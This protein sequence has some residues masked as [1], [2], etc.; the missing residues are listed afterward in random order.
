MNTLALRPRM[1]EKAYAVSQDLNT[2]VFMVPI[3][4]NKAAVTAAVSQQFKVT[5]EDVRVTVVKGKA[6][7]SYKKRSR[8]TVGHR[9]DMKKVYVR[10]KAGDS[11]PVFEAMT[12]EPKE[13]IMSKAVKKANEKAVEKAEKAEQPKQGRLRS[14]LGRAPRQTQSKGSGGK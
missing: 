11:I 12:E 5:V 6:K 9:A 14:A 1:S 10:L 2:Y 13:T 3:T 7:K 4:A 8:P